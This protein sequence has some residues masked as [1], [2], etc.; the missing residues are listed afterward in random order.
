MSNY[1]TQGLFATDTTGVGEMGGFEVYATGKYPAYMLSV[2]KEATKDGDGAFLKCI[3]QFFDCALEGKQYTSRI[4][5]WNKSPK[6]VEI[7]QKEIKALRIAL[8]LSDNEADESKYINQPVILDIVARN[9]RVDGKPTAEMENNLNKIEPYGQQQ[10]AQ[11]AP[12]AP[13]AQAQQQQFHQP[14]PQTAFVPPAHVAAQANGQQAPGQG[15]KPWLTK[16]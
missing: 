14:A 8:N 9:K 13:A 12:Q 16:R 15:V 2:V 7:A 5:L 6:A 3:Y 11:A 1:A 4:N 10:T